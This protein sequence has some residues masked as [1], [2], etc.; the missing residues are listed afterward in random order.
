MKNVSAKQYATIDKIIKA[1][2]AVQNSMK[3]DIKN[4]A[5]VT[6]KDFAKIQVINCDKFDYTKEDKDKIDLWAKSQGFVKVNKP[7]QRIDLDSISK[8]ADAT[9]L[10]VMQLLED[11]SNSNSNSNSKTIAKVAS[12]VKTVIK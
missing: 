6:Y 4:G 9:V 2:Q 7:Y 10:E 1:L 8:D 5:N 11:N 12:K 3:E